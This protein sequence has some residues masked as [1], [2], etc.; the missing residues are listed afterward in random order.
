MKYDTSHLASLFK[1]ANEG[2]IATGRKG[3]IVLVNPAACRMFGFTESE[4]LGQPIEVL[5]PIESRHHHVQLR[6][7]FYDKPSNRQMGHGRDLHGVRKDGVRFPVEVSLSVYTHEDQL[8]VM[9]FIVDITHRKSI[10]KKILQQQRELQKMTEELR[11]LNED[12]EMKVEDRTVILK[13]ALQNLEHSQNEL[14]ELLDKERQLNEMKSS[15][16]SMASHEFRTPLTTIL[17]SIALLSKYTQSDQQVQR[18]KHIT[19]VRDSVKHLNNLLD[20]FLSLGRLE[21]GKVAANISDVNLKNLMHETVEEMRRMVKHEQEILLEY[22]GDE[23]IESDKNMVKNILFNLISNAIKFSD[24]GKKIFIKSSATNGIIRLT[25]QDEGIGIP[26]DD[27]ERLFTS[28][29]RSRNVQNIQGTGLGLHIVKRYTDLLQ[30]TI[31]MKSEI[32]KGTTVSINL[33][34]KY[35]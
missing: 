7:A 28:F 15:F 17:S 25:V 27:F 4:L 2:F 6:E 12:L 13:E 22:S 18:D 30:G 19:K 34:S 23:M 26:K 9:A 21:E 16:V 24:A 29:F 8:F 5:I 33:P 20:D 32:N 14:R 1:Y 3:D 31:D 10:E 11:S 35:E